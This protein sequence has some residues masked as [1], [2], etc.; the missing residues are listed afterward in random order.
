LPQPEAL[1]PGEICEQYAHAREGIEL[2]SE[3]SRTLGQAT[4]PGYSSRQT[5]RFPAYALGP[6]RKVSDDPLKLN[7]RSDLCT[8]HLPPQAPCSAHE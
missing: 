3:V 6:L 8:T 1:R 4:S 2:H 7:Q 5:T